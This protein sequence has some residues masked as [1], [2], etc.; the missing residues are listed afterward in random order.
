MSLMSRAPASRHAAGTPP[1]A[2]IPIRLMVGGI[3]LAERLQKFIYP[4]Q[5]GAGRGRWSLDSWRARR[6]HV[7]APSPT[8]ASDARAHEL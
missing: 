2:T 4:M 7:G 1:A 8:A 6:D 5:A 3:F